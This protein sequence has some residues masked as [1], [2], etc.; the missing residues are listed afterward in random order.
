MDKI[1]CNSI[2]RVVLQNPRSL[3]LFTSLIEVQYSFALCQDLS[4]SA[5]CM[6]ETNINWG[7]KQAHSNLRAQMRKTWPHSA[8]SVSYTEEELTGPHQPGGTA[9]ILTDKLT[10]RVMD[11]GTNPFGLGRWNFLTLR[12]KNENRITIVM[13]YRI[14]EQSMASCGKTTSTAQQYR[15]LSKKMRTNQVHLDNPTPRRQMILDLQAWLSVKISEG[16]KIILAIDANEDITGKLGK[17]CTLNYTLD[18]PITDKDHDSSLATL[19][20]TCGLCNPLTAQ[21]KDTTPPHTYVR[22]SSRKDYVLVSQSI[23]P[24]VVRTGIL[25]FDRIFISNHRAC[26]ADLDARILFHEDT[27]TIQQVKNRSL[28]LHDPQIVDKYL[29]ALLK[30][31]KYHKLNDKIATLYRV[32]EAGEWADQHVQLYEHIDSLMT[33]SMIFAESHSSKSYSKKYSWSPVLKAAVKATQFWQFCLK[34]SKGIKVSEV[35]LNK[36]AKETKELR[37]PTTLL[38]SEILSGWK[39]SRVTLR[40]LQKEHVQLRVN[41]LES[42]AEARLVARTRGALFS[43]PDKLDR[44]WRKKVRRIL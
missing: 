5:L 21:H 38:Y 27:F 15:L 3:K 36:L 30:Q 32:A 37:N 13:A 43:H 18:T 2:F 42:L 4:V 7:H 6:P 29:E 12:G 11:K 39:T 22:G 1:E 35:L 17:P 20:A 10:S 34:R 9:T 25:P 40:T 16:H 8:H 28:R 14:C 24:A 31:I 41:H 44:I 26:F 33:E 19:M 23:L